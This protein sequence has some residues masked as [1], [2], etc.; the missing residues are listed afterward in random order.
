M[1]AHKAVKIVCEIRI[2]GRHQRLARRLSPAS[3]GAPY[4]D[5]ANVATFAASDWAGTM[6]A[7]EVNFTAGGVVD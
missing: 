3:F 2:A 1:H 4:D 5:V 7:T 6:T